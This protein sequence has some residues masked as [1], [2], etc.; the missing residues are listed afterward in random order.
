M[1]PQP[2]F[3]LF[4]HFTQKPLRIGLLPGWRGNNFVN[5]PRALELGTCY[6]LAHY[7]SFICFGDA[8]SFDEGAACA[9]LGDEAERGERGKQECM[10]SRIDEICKGDK[11]RGKPDDG[12]VKRDDEDLGVRVEGAGDVDVVG[13]EAA[14]DVAAGGGGEGTG[15][16]GGCYV[17]AAVRVY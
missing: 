5:E 13:D 17:C 16:A 14:E 6:P 9:A 1:T 15:G 3:Y 8:H 7:E 2:L 12:A 4:Q 10:R 11:G